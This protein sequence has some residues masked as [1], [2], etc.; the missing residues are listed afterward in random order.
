M[1]PV[2]KGDVLGEQGPSEPKPD[3]AVGLPATALDEEGRARFLVLCLGGLGK[4][5]NALPVLHAI[6]TTY[7]DSRT[8]WL[9]EE[10]M[11]PLLRDHPELDR[12]HGVPRAEWKA[13]SWWG[14]R[15]AMKAFAH[16]LGSAG[17]TVTVDLHGNRSSAP[18]ARASRAAIRVSY[19]PPE[20]ATLGRRFYTCRIVPSPRVRHVAERHLSLLVPLAVGRAEPVYVFPDL[21]R[22]RER[23]VAKLGAAADGGYAVLHPGA[24][25]PSR[26]WPADSYAELARGI[27]S[28]LSLDVFV[29]ASG[30]VERSRAEG[31]VKAAGEGARVVP[32]L[33][34]DELAGFLSGAALFVGGDAGPMHLASGLGVPTVAVFG[35]TRPERRGPRG[36]RA[37][38]V[39]AGLPCAGCGRSTCTYGTDA[40]VKKIEPGAVLELAKEALA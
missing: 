19:A 11:A 33:E 3:A 14:R 35:P 1:P 8:G 23:A 25:A 15:R 5:V 31:V 28:G 2:R 37:R 7:P 29:P 6:R 4:V 40:C 32:D 9:V 17:Y 36:P 22:A 18:F 38:S 13:L 20:G 12:V 39:E 30:D 27:A 26:Q 16:E 21:A 34:L 10:E 24:S